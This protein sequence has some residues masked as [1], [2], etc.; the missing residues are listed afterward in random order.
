MKGNISMKKLLNILATISLATIPSLTILSCST[1]NT[2]NNP[3]ESVD[4]NDYLK[5]IEEFKKEVNTIVT[6]ELMKANEKL[7]ELTK[8]EKSNKF[9]NQSN[10][11][12]FSNKESTLDEEDKKN[13]LLDINNKLFI[14]N[15]KTKLNEIKKDTK[16]NII[17]DGVDNIF[18]KLDINWD[19]LKISHTNYD[20][21]ENVS[22]DKKEGFTSN[23]KLNLSLITNYKDKEGITEEHKI[24]SSFIY[25]LTNDE[26]IKYF[27]ETT[28]KELK[29]KYFIDSDKNNKNSLLDAVS[30]GLDT[31]ND[32][33]FNNEKV[34]SNYFNNDNFKSSLLNFIKTSL[35]SSENNEFIKKLNISFSSSIDTFSKVDYTVKLQNKSPK[36]YAWK[37]EK[38]N[39]KDIFDFIFKSEYA[40]P[41]I[42]PTKDETLYKYLSEETTSMLKNY[43][44]DLETFINDL[45]YFDKDEKEKLQS[46]DLSATSKLGYVYLKGLQFK[47]GSNYIQELP[48][49]KIL[50]GYAIDIDDKN[51]EGENYKTIENSKTLSSVYYN[52][53]NGIQA[54]HNVFGITTPKNERAMS[55]FTGKTAGMKDNL[56]DYIKP[57]W[58]QTKEDISKS[59]SLD[60]PNQHEYLT[61]LKYNGNQSTYNWKFI[62]R[63]F[64]ISFAV[65]DTGLVNNIIYYQGEKSVEMNFALD[66]VNINFVVDGI[67]RISDKDLTVIERASE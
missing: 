12:K 46:K 44:K 24:D 58:A 45:D 3:N 64:N 19:S 29:N 35:K 6:N 30:L 36:E 16:Y 37:D 66:F 28:I 54:F 48:E 53:M 10:I 27:G 1:K 8:D 32:K 40:E 51:W 31:K 49:F 4:V 9:L 55:A 34:V 57:S 43:R 15:I 61:K 21:S 5:I 47:I 65:K 7:I 20:K 38:T 14:Q 52:A 18:D 59:L 63:V 60:F 56:W 41:N 62:K 22:N 11:T 42:S 26:A 2:A 67:W 23:V 17:L 33:F 13:L 50:T 39:G 25:S